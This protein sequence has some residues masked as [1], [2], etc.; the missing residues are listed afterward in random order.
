MA[1]VAGPR[2]LQCG[3]HIE[4]L[5]GFEKSFRILLPAFTVEVHRQEET[6]LVQ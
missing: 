3:G 6:G 2:T 1:A 5:A 4:S